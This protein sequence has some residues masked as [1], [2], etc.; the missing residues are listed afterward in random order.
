LAELKTRLDKGT[1]VEPSKKTLAEY[2]PEILTPDH[3]LWTQA[4]HGRYICPLHP[5]RHC[6]V[7]AWGDVAD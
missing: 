7:E 4:D 1:Y 2:V 5:P 6:P 3:R